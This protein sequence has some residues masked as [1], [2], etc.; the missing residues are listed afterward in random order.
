MEFSD[1]SNFLDLRK[2][3][4]QLHVRMYVRKYREGIVLSFELY[5]YYRIIKKLELVDIL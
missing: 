3:N 1:A 4:T 5:L 2:Q